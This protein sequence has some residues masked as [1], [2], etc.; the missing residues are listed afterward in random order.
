MKTPTDI[1][2]SVKQ[3]LR[4]L[5]RAV[6]R[7]DA[8]ENTGFKQENGLLNRLITDLLPEALFGIGMGFVMLFTGVL[9]ILAPDFRYKVMFGCFATICLL[10]CAYKLDAVSRQFRAIQHDK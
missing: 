7:E 10:A 1:E 3:L 6:Q 4:R 5:D 9:A 2:Q 8:M